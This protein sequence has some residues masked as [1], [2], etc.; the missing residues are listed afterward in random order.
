MYATMNLYTTYPD[1]QRL[2]NSVNVDLRKNKVKVSLKE[3]QCWESSP[4]KILCGVNSNL[5]VDG[6]KQL[7]L[8][9]LKELEKRL[10]RHG[11]LNAM[12]L[13]DEPLPELIVSLKGIRPLKLPKDEEEKSRLTFDTFPWESKMAYYLEASDSA[14]Y[15]LAPLVDLL[16][17]TNTLS[18]TFGPS[19]YIMDVP[20]QNQK[21]SIEKVQSPYD[22]VHQY[23]I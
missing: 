13:Y 1:I 18:N 2:L 9:K 5:C 7:L 12:D 14:W 11:R 15:R 10:C 20:A 22:W 17:E 4:K 23:G 8:H 21:I 3:L 6:I 19:A 16:V